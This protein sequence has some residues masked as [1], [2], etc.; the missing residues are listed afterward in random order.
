MN[1]FVYLNYYIFESNIISPILYGLIFIYYYYIFYCLYNDIQIFDNYIL[2]DIVLLLK[3]FLWNN[4]LIFIN[5]CYNFDY[6]HKLEYLKSKYS[7]DLISKYSS[8]I[9][10]Y[11]LSMK[12]YY[13]LKS[14]HLYNYTINLILKYPSIKKI[15]I[16]YFLIPIIKLN[17]L[18]IS[19]FTI[20]LNSLGH[21]EHKKILKKQ[22]IYKHKKK[23]YDYIL[24]KLPNNSEIEK[25]IEPNK[26][27][28]IIPEKS[29]KNE[30]ETGN[31]NSILNIIEFM[32][33]INNND[34]DNNNNDN[35]INLNTQL[36]EK[37]ENNENINKSKNLQFC[38]NKLNLL[39]EIDS[40]KIENID[41]INNNDNDINEY[42]V[43]D[44]IKVIKSIDPIKI[45]ENKLKII[46]D[47]PNE[48]KITNDEP[49]E[50]KIINNEPNE[51]INYEDID[52]GIKIEELNIINKNTT[53]NQTNNQTNNITEK[54]IIKIGKKINK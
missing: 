16:Y 28:I 32:S 23:T 9:I 43:I 5:Y 53:N 45:V 15:I 13:I 10:N 2:Y 1:I 36:I 19:I 33:E 49:N 31:D 21:L 8:N 47:E 7:I 38:E 41:N 17:Y 29:L 3:N 34:D 6:V 54:K 50:L 11:Y 48:L 22:K 40:L 14:N 35:K 18:F 4:G 24:S 37:N 20:L 12:Q 46:N 27:D 52:F 30:T 44:D 51:L 25:N 26:N 39:N 42:L